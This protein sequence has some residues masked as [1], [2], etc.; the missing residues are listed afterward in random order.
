M[1]PLRR[2]PLPLLVAGLV[3]AA[4][5]C[6]GNATQAA[7]KITFFGA[8]DGTITTG[9]SVVLTWKTE[10]AEK[11]R[12]VATP[13][14]TGKAKVVA[15]F[16]SGDTTGC[17]VNPA[18]PGSDCVKDGTLSLSP[19][20]ETVYNLEAVTGAGD[21]TRD[22]STGALK[23]PSQCADLTADP[24][25]SL[26]VILV[27]VV[28][29]AVVKLTVGGKPT[30]TVAPG[31]DVAADYEV[32]GATEFG[33]GVLGTDASGKTTYTACGEAGDSSAPC[34]LPARN[35]DGSL[36]DT[37]KV[38]V[39]GIQATTKLT[40]QATNGADDGKG[41]VAPGTNGG[42]VQIVVPGTPAVGSLHRRPRPPYPRAP[43]GRRSPSPG[44]YPPPTPSPPPSTPA[45]RGPS[46]GW[47]AAP[48]STEAAAAPVM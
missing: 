17:Q 4:A 13:V 26:Q 14:A 25:A 32:T 42:T 33:F 44:R 39:P 48:P 22:P 7:P 9:G 45:P 24:N 11:V 31:T 23:H 18:F 16:A 27:R 36:P 19:G 37:G 2:A 34:N 40:G 12:V 43:P 35:A 8:D 6:G 41:D 1:I 28:P 21:C 15:T 20:E 29:A 3:A 30:A 5:G 10:N 47:P 38:T 46:P